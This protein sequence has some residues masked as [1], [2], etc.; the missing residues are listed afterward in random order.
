V[1]RH[2]LGGAHASHGLVCGQLLELLLLSV[3]EVLGQVPVLE[4]EKGGGGG[5]AWKHNSW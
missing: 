4:E 3:G 1:T 5:A 2:S